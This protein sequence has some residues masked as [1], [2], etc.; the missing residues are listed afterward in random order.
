M[1][2]PS[3]GNSFMS[4]PFMGNPS[5]GNS[6][7][8]LVYVPEDTYGYLIEKEP[9]EVAVI[10]AEKKHT[11]LHTTNSDE[12]LLDCVVLDPRY[13]PMGFR[14]Y[15][16]KKVRGRRLG[17]TIDIL[18]DKPICVNETGKEYRMLTFKGCGAIA[19]MGKYFNSW[20]IDPY[21]W[22]GC[23][24]QLDRTWGAVSD[25]G[26]RLEAQKDFLVFG[27]HGGKVT[28]YLSANTIPKQIVEVIYA[29]GEPQPLGQPIRL[30]ETNILGSDYLNAENFLSWFFSN[31]GGHS[32][33][34]YSCGERK[35][36]KADVGKL[37][38]DKQITDN[39][40]QL[41]MSIAQTNKTLYPLGKEMRYTVGSCLLGNSYI[42]GEVKDFENLTIGKLDD[43][44]AHTEGKYLLLAAYEELMRNLARPIL[45]QG[46]KIFISGSELEK[47]VQGENISPRKIKRQKTVKKDT[48]LIPSSSFGVPPF[49]VHGYITKSTVTRNTVTRSTNFGEEHCFTLREQSLNKMKICT[50]KRALQL[51]A[52]LLQ[53]GLQF[54]TRRHYLAMVSVLG[55]QETK[56][57]LSGDLWYRELSDTLISTVDYDTSTLYDDLLLDGEE[58]L[59]KNGKNIELLLGRKFFKSIGYRKRTEVLAEWDQ[60]KIWPIKADDYPFG[61]KQQHGL[62]LLEMSS[63]DDTKEMY[64]ATQEDQ[65]SPGT[66]ICPPVVVSN[67]IDEETIDEDETQ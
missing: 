11:G 52:Q 21:D 25:I 29:H 44:E 64:F 62:Y 41:L 1:S 4:Y 49:F 46:R 31:A 3:M 26:A 7:S 36:N 66:L 63:R 40:L 48:Y 13:V 17:R 24:N 33:C 15:E 56:N 2:N 37:V 23:A 14:D 59:F 28:P 65:L 58:I 35:V 55:C 42:S 18:L 10:L 51:E 47:Y 67:A 57:L 5:M 60:E 22:P 27:Q 20:V 30:C 16:I 19:E 61:S 50:L 34:R 12:L 38:Q 43:K 39:F 9:I 8:E 32:S 53:N 6:R 45:Q 54:A